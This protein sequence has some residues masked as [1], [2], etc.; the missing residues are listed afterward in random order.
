[1]QA[2]EGAGT[3]TSIKLEPVYLLPNESKREDLTAD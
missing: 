2:L 3:H 1:M